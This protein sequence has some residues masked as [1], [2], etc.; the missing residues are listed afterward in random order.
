MG[1]DDTRRWWATVAIGIVVSVVATMLRDTSDWGWGAVVLNTAM[2]AAV[3]VILIRSVHGYA[4][5]RSG[6]E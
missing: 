2:G 5:A 1:A 6:A 3:V 4:R